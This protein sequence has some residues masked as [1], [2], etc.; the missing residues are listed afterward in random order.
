MKFSSQLPKAMHVTN[1]VELEFRNVGFSGVRETGVPGEKPSE[2]SENQ[3]KTH[4]CQIGLDEPSPHCPISATSC[5][6]Y[7]FTYRQFS[8]VNV[9][10]HPRLAFIHIP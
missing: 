1:L 8:I 6:S 4:T 2:L 9:F 10:G 5:I 3:Q 7:T